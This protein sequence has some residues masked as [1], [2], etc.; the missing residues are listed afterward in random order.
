M[1]HNNVISSLRFLNYVNLA[2]KLRN[3]KEIKVFKDKFEN[4]LLPESKEDCIFLTDAIIYFLSSK[5]EMVIDMAFSVKIKTHKL[6]VTFN[7]ILLMAYFEKYLIIDI[8]RIEKQVRVNRYFLNQGHLK[9]TERLRDEHKKFCSIVLKL[10]K[11]SIAKNDL[12]RQ[13][14]KEIYPFEFWIREKLN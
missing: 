7:T 9:I 6:K 1:T 2:F 14:D 12:L 11:P 4:Y 10:I 5:F 13:L 3:L 8:A